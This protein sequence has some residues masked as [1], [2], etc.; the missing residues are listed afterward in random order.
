MCC[1]ERHASFAGV[2]RATSDTGTRS[3]GAKVRDKDGGIREYRGSVQVVVTFDSLCS[4]VR[5]YARHQ[6]DANELCA[7][8]DDAEAAGNPKTRSNLLR[9]F[10]NPVDGMTGS[11]PG[12]SFTAEQGALLKLLSTRL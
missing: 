3:V 2:D 1:L 5:S 9:S 7:I 11:Q 6:A 12:K 10:R 8:L 4:L